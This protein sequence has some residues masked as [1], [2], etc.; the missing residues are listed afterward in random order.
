MTYLHI[1]EQANIIAYG[2]YSIIYIIVLLLDVVLK[3]YGKN[4]YVAGIL[5]MLII[6]AIFTKEYIT[7]IT[8]LLT[9]LTI[10]IYLMIS[11]IKGKNNQEGKEI[12]KE[13]RIGFFLGIWNVITLIVVLFISNCRV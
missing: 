6:M 2:I 8:I 3:K 12:A 9:L 1:I 7:G 13:L 10:S 11:K 5:L 4:S